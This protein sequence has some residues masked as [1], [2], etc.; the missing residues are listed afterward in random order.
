MVLLEAMAGYNPVVAVKSSGIDDVI[1]NGKNGYKTE[2]DLEKWSAKIEELLQEHGKYE[3]NSK[4]ARKV[5][6]DYS[7]AE[8]GKEAERLYYKILKLNKYQ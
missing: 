6:E 5:A 8:M 2:E 7:I 3:E 4:A 1:E